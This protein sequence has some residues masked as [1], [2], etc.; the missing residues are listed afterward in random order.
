MIDP[1]LAATAVSAGLSLLDS[2][3]SPARPER[4]TGD[5]VNQADFLR[6]LVAQLANQ[7]PLNP[8]DSA[9]FSAQLAQFS[10]LEQLM[11]INQRLAGAV[12]GGDALAGFDLLSLLGK[13]VRGVGSTLTVREGVASTLDFTLETAGA[14]EARILDD[15]GR[16][17]ARIDL[18][19]LPAGAHR[20]DL[21]ALA[22]APSLADGT[23]TVVLGRADGPGQSTPIATFVA[24]RVT[25]VDLGANPPILVLDGLRLALT[26]VRE[27]H[28]APAGP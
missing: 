12:G 13:E 24:G 27:I 26:D 20:F 19:S 2:A 22:D 21:A 1:T 7:D 23:Y 15:A 8:L 3:T 28:L 16:E 17:V 6:L 10:S 5:V 9:N 18:G 11:Q 14:V 4:Q 25:G